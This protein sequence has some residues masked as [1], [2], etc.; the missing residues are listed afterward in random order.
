MGWFNH[1]LVPDFYGNIPS[2]SAGWTTVF[3]VTLWVKER[4]PSHRRKHFLHEKKTTT[5]RMGVFFLFEGNNFSNKKEGR[6]E[7]MGPVKFHHF[8]RK[9]V[10]SRNVTRVLFAV[11]LLPVVYR[12]WRSDWRY[13]R[14]CREV[15]MDEISFQCY[16]C[17]SKSTPPKFNIAPE[18]RWL[19]HKPFLLGR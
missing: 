5:W 2:L 19:E 8:E 16:I 15:A 4:H 18:K 11:A 12:F 3:Q 10:I 14:S 17:I 7:V 9:P 1:H 13:D 6:G